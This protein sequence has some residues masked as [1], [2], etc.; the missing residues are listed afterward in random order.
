MDQPLT[1]HRLNSIFVID[2]D[3]IS[4]FLVET[5]LQDMNISDCILSAT[6]GLEALEVIEERCSDDATNGC[7]ELILLDINMPIMDGF[8]FM[9]KFQKLPYPHLD[10]AKV[11]ILTSSSNLQDVEKSKHFSIYGYMIK[12]LTKDKLGTLL[13]ER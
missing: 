2:D 13:E 8:E 12:P 9:D 11:I 5:I 1:K 7:P 10:K 3:P 4:I 6:N